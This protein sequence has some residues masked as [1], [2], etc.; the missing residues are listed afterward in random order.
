MPHP[1]SHI[2]NEI[3]A[4]K[5]VSVEPF[6]GYRGV[7]G[8]A[9]SNNEK[10]WFIPK[11]EWWDEFLT[12]LFQL[13][14]TNFVCFDIRRLLDFPINKSNIV[15]VRTLLDGGEGTLLRKMQQN[16]P[17]NPL[18]EQLAEAEQRMAAN[19][20]SIRTTN[21]QLDGNLTDS[22]P[23]Q[24]FERYT[25]VRVLSI[26]ALF[27]EFI[28]SEVLDSWW[29]RLDFIR[30]VHEV[31][32]SGIRIDKEFVDTQLTKRQETADA[33]CFRSMLQFYKNGYVT[34]FYNVAGTK[35]GRLR[36][37]GGF[38]AM[39][40]P[41]GPCRKAI[42][43]RFEGGKIYS[44]DY[45]AIDYRSIVSSIGG[46]FA[47]NYRGHR[48]FHVRTAKFIFEEVDE[49][50]R[51]AIKSISYTSIY[52]GSQE[53]LASRTGL[54]ID[55]VKKV[56]GKLDPHIKPIHEFRERLWGLFQMS[57]QIDIPG[58]GVYRKQDDETMHPGKL[59]A[60]YAQG[61]SAYVFERAFVEVHRFLEAHGRGSC[62]IFPVHDELVLDIHP[63]DEAA[64][65]AE[66]V[67]VIMEKALVDD[68]VVNIK[69]G[70][71]YGEIE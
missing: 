59:L 65:M 70:R 1:H 44:F 53:T 24:F 8:I 9:I 41:H 14:Q 71:S 49:V 2:I 61:Y 60:L 19:M 10:Y 7:Y 68:F 63:D 28:N 16:H 46:L 50:R 40:V 30:A 36:P 66:S 38:G 12:E 56:L 48:D 32:L 57:G 43:S 45:N 64:G 13:S 42:I 62:I 6:R 27:K 69:K 55:M 52:G 33:K 35:T 26:Y 34:A 21:T 54:S 51:E 37:E 67:R 11:K 20:R 22:M 23:P 18:T 25:K 29:R 39:G 58:V 17:R 3:R 4:S 5:Y 31:E 47:E 15:D